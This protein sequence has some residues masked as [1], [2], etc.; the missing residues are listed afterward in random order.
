MMVRHY[1]ISDAQRGRD[2]ERIRKTHAVN[3]AWDRWSPVVAA[4]G[5]ALFFVMVWPAVSA[6]AG[7]IGA[8][9]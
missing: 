7:A 5:V 8:V 3:E 1:E 6:L 4:V 9:L 2:L